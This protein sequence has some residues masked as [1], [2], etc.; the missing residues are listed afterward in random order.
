M[1]FRRLA[2]PVSKLLLAALA[3]GCG[4]SHPPDPATTPARADAIASPSAIPATAPAT[5]P[6][7]QDTREAVILPDV[8]QLTH[9]FDKAGEAYFS[10]DMKWIIF[11][12]SPHGDQHYQTEL[13]T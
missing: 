9:G 11:Q 8:V 13:C 5:G 10:R 7:Q 4:R 3:A 12:A 6:A 2:R 1:M